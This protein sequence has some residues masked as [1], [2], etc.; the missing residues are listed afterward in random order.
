L[1]RNEIPLSR[2]IS[3]STVKKCLPYLGSDNL[4]KE[5]RNLSTCLDRFPCIKRPFS[6]NGI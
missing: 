5:N 2:K 4:S 1:N 6:M 3:G